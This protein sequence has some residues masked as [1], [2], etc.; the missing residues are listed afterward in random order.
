MERDRLYLSDEG[1][2]RL[3]RA[4]LGEGSYPHCL[5]EAILLYVLEHPGFYSK[6][7]SMSSRG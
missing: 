6:G 5:E 7:D 2:R 4:G 3:K 1:V